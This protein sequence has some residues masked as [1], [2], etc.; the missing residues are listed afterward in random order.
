MRG[1]LM[2]YDAI[3]TV[4][5][6]SDGTIEEGRGH[7]NPAGSYYA[8]GCMTVRRNAG[9]RDQLLELGQKIRDRT[10]EVISR[11]EAGEG[12]REQSGAVRTYY[13]DGKPVATQSY[14]NRTGWGNYAIL[15]EVVR[16]LV[17]RNADWWGY[18]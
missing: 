11:I 18:R 7:I 8:S 6:G 16:D 4:F 12:F 10:G 13:L 14:G 3:E 15:W 1:A 17:P 2:G 5:V 9:S